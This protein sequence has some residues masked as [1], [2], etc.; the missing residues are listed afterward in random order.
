MWGGCGW[1]ENRVISAVVKDA[2]EYTFSTAV[3]SITGNGAV[4]DYRALHKI[5]NET[6]T[7]KS[8]P[9]L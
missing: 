1:R 8:R 3:K 4:V 6:R 5:I 9:A 2:S 7:S